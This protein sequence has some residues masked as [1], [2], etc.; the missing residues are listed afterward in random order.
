MQHLF[1][2]G[3]GGWKPGYGYTQVPRGIT[4]RFYTDFAKNLM[5]GM[6]YNILDGSYTTVAREVGEFMQCPNMQ[7]SGQDDAWTARSEARLNQVYWGDE[8]MVVGVPEGQSGKL[9]QFFERLKDTM[10]QGDEGV[11][12]WLACS[13]LQLKQVGGRLHGLNAD[14]FR[15]RPEQSGRYRIKNPKGGFIWI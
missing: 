5:T 11:I 6:E 12:H 4:V 1:L 7:I 10:S 8:S 13:T 3:H 2:S 15:H 14:D 9:N